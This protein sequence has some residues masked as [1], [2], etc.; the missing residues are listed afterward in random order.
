[1][2]GAPERHAR[3]LVQAEPSA[4]KAGRPAARRPRHLLQ[5]GARL[6]VARDHGRARRP[7]GRQ[8]S[9]ARAPPPGH[10][11][12][13]AQAPPEQ[14]ARPVLPAARAGRRGRVLP[15]GGPPDVPGRGPV[16]AGGVQVRLVGRLRGGRRAHLRQRHG[17]QRGG[18]AP[19][20]PG[21]DARA[22]VQRGQGARPAGAAGR[23]RVSDTRAQGAGERPRRERERTA[24]AGQS[25]AQRGEMSACRSTASR[26][27]IGETCETLCGCL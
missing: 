26:W 7:G 18:L 27:P 1:M 22:R 23:A 20:L 10:L 15:A 12:A 25:G 19:L 13:R 2:G 11:S 6:R 17:I 5:A 24:A 3:P 14:R 9:R 16:G 4:R 21:A 8:R